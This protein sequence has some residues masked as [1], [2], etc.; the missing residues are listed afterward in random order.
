LPVAIKEAAGFVGAAV[1]LSE[2]VS[3]DDDSLHELYIGRAEQNEMSEKTEMY[4]E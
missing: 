4:E 2:I 3:M 1:F